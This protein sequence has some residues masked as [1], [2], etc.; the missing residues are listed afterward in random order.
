MDK[1]RQ[2]F[3][4]DEICNMARQISQLLDKGYSV[5]ICKSRSGLK[6]FKVSRKY[7]QIRK[8]A[9]ASDIQRDCRIVE[10]FI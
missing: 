6:I 10:N 4:E 5:E 2:E 7:E 1:T 9:A 8:G 3:Y